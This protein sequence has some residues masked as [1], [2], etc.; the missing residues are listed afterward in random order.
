MLRCDSRAIE[1]RRNGYKLVKDDSSLESFNFQRLNIE[2]SI[3]IRQPTFLY[4]DVLPRTYC[5]IDAKLSFTLELCCYATASELSSLVR[6]TILQLYNKFLSADGKMVDY[7]GIRESK[8]FG[9]YVALSAQLQR[10][11][12]S[13]FH[14]CMSA[15]HLLQSFNDDKNSIH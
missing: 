10:V 4:V 2:A 9:S 13:A 7:K 14:S 6:K 8:E 1:L 5:F 12:V 15:T 11:E 3:M